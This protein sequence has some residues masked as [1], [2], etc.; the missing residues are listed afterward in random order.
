MQRLKRI[1][2]GFLTLV[3]LVTSVPVQAFAVQDTGNAEASMDSQDVDFEGTNAVGSLLAEAIAQEQQSTIVSSEDTPYEN[4]YTLTDIVVQGSVATVTYDAMEEAQLVVA[5]YSDDGMQLLNT[6]KTTV[7][8]EETTATVTFSGQ[9]PQYFVAAAYLLDVYDFSPLCPSYETP[10]YTQ[11]MQELLDMTVADCVEEYGEERI[12]NLDDNAQTNF[13]VYAEGAVLL[14][15]EDGVNT[16]TSADDVNLVYVIANADDRVT[17]L[18]EG[19]IVVYEYADGELLLIKVGSITVDGTTVT[20]QGTDMELEEVFAI[21]KVEGEAGT[22]EAV[23]DPEGLDEH[24]EYLG[25]DAPQTYEIEGGTTNK[26]AHVFYLWGEKNDDTTEKDVWD[27]DLKA[28]IIG[29]G[30]FEGTVSFELE[31]KLELYISTKRQFLEFKVTPNINFTAELS[32]YLNFRSKQLG[33]G[34][35]IPL[36]STGIIAKIRPTIN[37]KF[38]GK[39]EFEA[40]L[41]L[42]IGAAVEHRAGGN[43]QCRDLSKTP[44]M[45]PNLEFEGK[46]FFGVDLNPGVYVASEKLFKADMTSMI[47]FELTGKLEYKVTD[48][49]GP[50]IHDCNACIDGDLSFVWKLK[51]ELKLLNNDH[52]KLEKTF[53][54]GSVKLFDFYCSLDERKFGKGECPNY[55]YRVYITV[56]D[57]NLNIIEGVEVGYI[58]ASEEDGIKQL[59]FT[60]AN[61]VVMDNTIFGNSRNLYLPRGRYTFQTEYGGEPIR[62]P[63]PVEVYSYTSTVLTSNEDY[64]KRQAELKLLMIKPD[65]IKTGSVLESGVC[66]NNLEWQVYSSGLLEITGKG[67]MDQ[68]SSAAKAPWY[69]YKDKIK[70][71]R[72]GEPQLDPAGQDP[73]DL[74]TVGNH[75]FSGYTKLEKVILEDNVRQLGLSSFANCTKLDEIKM[76]VDLDVYYNSNSSSNHSFSGCTNVTKIQYTYGQTGKMTQRM[77]SA[78]SSYSYIYSLEN[79]ARESLQYAYMEEGITNIAAHAFYNAAQLQEIFIP[80]TITTIGSSAFAGCTGLT[81]I[82]IPEGLTTF[83]TDVF[84]GCTGLT[85]IYIPTTITSIPARCFAYCTGLTELVIPDTVTALEMGAFAGCRNITKLTMPVDLA[86]YQDPVTASDSYNN[87]FSGMTKVTEIQYTYGRTGKMTKRSNTYGSSYHHARSPEMY[88]K[89]ALESVIIDSGILDISSSAFAGCSA[90]SNVLFLGNPLSISS[91][92]FSGVTADALYPYDNDTWTE[93]TMQN[94]GGTLTWTPYILDEDGSIRT[95]FDSNTVELEPEE[96]EPEETEPVETEPA[97]TEPAETEP[98]ETEPAETE[99]AETEPAET[100]SAETEPVETEPAETEPAETEPAETEPVETEP[101][102][103][104]SVETEA[105]ETVPETTSEQIPS[106]ASAAP[107]EDVPIQG[108]IG[109]GGTNA[110]TPAAN[111][112]YGGMNEAEFEDATGAVIQST[113][114]NGLVSGSEYV[115]F[116]LVSMEAEDLLAPGNILYI[117]Q[118]PADNNGSLTFRYIQKTPTDKFNVFACGASHRHLRNASI[119]FPNLSYNGDLH[120]AEPTVTYSGKTLVEGVDYIVLD[121]QGAENAGD[122]LCTIRGICNYTGLITCKY[123]VNAGVNTVAMAA[124]DLDGQATVWIDGAEYGVATDGDMCYV[125]LPDSDARTMTIYTYHTDND[126]DDQTNYP[127]GMKV[128]TLENEAGIYTASRQE[129]FDDI[130]QYAGMSIRVTGKKGIRMITAMEQTKKQSLTAEGLAGYTLKEYGTVVAWAGKLENGQPLVLGQPYALSNYAYRKGI[131]DAVFD[132]RDN[133]MQYTNVLVNFTDEQCSKVLALRPYIILQD[134]QGE[135]ITIYGGIL[136]RSIGYIA[137]Q[138]RNAFE[139][140][141]EAYAYIWDIIRST[142]GNVYDDEFVPA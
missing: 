129:S 114:F 126:T 78:G 42:T 118:A 99:P 115:M 72:I 56:K 7:T 8:A 68:F 111:A 112:V 49:S 35:T 89:A 43:W 21:M 38:S 113:S 6:A 15:E 58:D 36:G 16:V 79:T 141:T 59:G 85:S 90:L 25:T 60:N 83:G 46:V 100:E 110:S 70:S 17:S 55:R 91:N 133:L 9:M 138:N 29:K 30:K 137:Y 5:L 109:S 12:Y 45:E 98:A 50:R 67:A 1:L 23:F 53:L 62:S 135:T 124:E 128:W 26:I 105:Q 37:L 136:Y 116:A 130:L 106:S 86:F 28:D 140:R 63:E 131:Q 104:E 71:L 74:I 22:E 51:I 117:G 92:S 2:A 13:A 61:G 39:I 97:E 95:E 18:T 69:K 139:P 14:Y 64:W 102:E 76:P 47:G 65:S 75:A 108:V 88:S 121:G 54:D 123:T 40:K 20:I 101:V 96:T 24:M 41:F 125:N 87:S 3:L 94:Y 119:T 103:T 127:V 82:D 57:A 52:L 84:S 73:S 132:Y 44:K 27:K 122:Y 48:Y 32:G 107:E 77:N 120:I 134:S 33:K 11:D 80:Q 66:G 4:G 81:Q 142:Y 31:T 19:S 34:F 93:D 10:M